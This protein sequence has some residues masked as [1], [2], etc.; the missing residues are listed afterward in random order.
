MKKVFNEDIAR[1]IISVL[2]FT[3]SFLIAS[4][5]SVLITGS[6]S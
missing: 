1:I 3:I 4:L 6:I 2:L 5:I